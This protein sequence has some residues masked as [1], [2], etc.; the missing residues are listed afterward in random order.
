MEAQVEPGPLPWPGLQVEFAGS[1]YWPARQSLVEAQCAVQVPVA[2][3]LAAQMPVA[4][5]LDQSHG[6]P[7]GRPQVESVGSQRPPAH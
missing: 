2:G 5:S 6:V 3:P 7:G 4:Q 1:Q